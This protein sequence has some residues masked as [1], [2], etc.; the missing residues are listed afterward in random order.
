MS[1]D[2]DAVDQLVGRARAGR[3]SSVPRQRDDARCRPPSPTRRRPR[4]PRRRA[5]RAASTPSSVER[6]QVAL[7]DRACRRRRRRSETIAAT[8]AARGRRPRR[9]ARSRRARRRSTIASGHALGGVADGL[10]R[11][12]VRRSSRRRRARGSARPARRSPRRRRDGR[13][14]ASVRT[15]SGSER[16]ASS[17]KYSCAESGRPCSANS[18]AEDRAE[19]RLVVRERAVEVEDRR[20]RVGIG[21]SSVASAACRRRRSLLAL[22]AAFV[23]ALWNLLLARARDPQAA[24]AVALLDGGGRLRVPARLAWR[25]RPAAS[26]RTSSRAGARAR[27]L[28]AARRRV[29]PAPLS[30]VYP[31]ARGVAPVLVLVGR[32]R[33]ARRT[34]DAR[35]RSA[36]CCSSGPGSCSCA[37][38]PSAG[39]GVAARR[40]RSPA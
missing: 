13:G 1:V 39:R 16:P 35:G 17:S 31:L 32:R 2:V 4:C 6:P 26:G 30:V 10:A 38:S 34:D 40:S 21:L 15:I 18:S 28:R 33:R 20:A 14:R 3:G 12:L 7:R 11:V 25:R 22:A 36:A 24:T 8:A 5:R 29:P 19:D 37:A 23:H 9:P 27:L